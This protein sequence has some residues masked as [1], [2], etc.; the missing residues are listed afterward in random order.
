[1][2]RYWKERWL[3]AKLELEV[4]RVH[5]QSIK[6]TLSGPYGADGAYA[7]ARAIKAETTALMEYSIILRIDTDLVVHGKLPDN[8]EGQAAGAE[9]K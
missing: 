3:Q 2:E 7:Y 8:E 1:M 5:V 6:R 4:A 9:E